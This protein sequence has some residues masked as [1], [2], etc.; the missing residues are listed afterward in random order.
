MKMLKWVG[1]F[2]LAWLAIFLIWAPLAAIAYITEIFPWLANKVAI[3]IR[4]TFIELKEE[5]EELREE[6]K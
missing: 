1:W 6:A 5:L 4:E 2:V 3:P